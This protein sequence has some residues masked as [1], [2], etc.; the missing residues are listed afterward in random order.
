MWE[1]L[2]S[3]TS[4]RAGAGGAGA[5]FTLLLGAAC[6]GGRFVSAAFDFFLQHFSPATALHAN[7]RQAT[8]RT[9]FK[10][11]DR[12]FIQTRHRPARTA[13]ALPQVPNG[14]EDAGLVAASPR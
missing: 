3:R 12:F 5:Y 13:R 9:D 6:V 4:Q 11:K 8:A 7:V 1:R 2:F 10:R 14:L